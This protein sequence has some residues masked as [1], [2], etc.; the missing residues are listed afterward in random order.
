MAEARFDVADHR[1]CDDGIR[2]AKLVGSLA[3]IASLCG[4]EMSR[5]DYLI[6]ARA[7]LALRMAQFHER[8]D[9]LI[10]PTL[11]LTAFAAGEEVPP[12]MWEHPQPVA[13]PQAHNRLHAQKA[14]L[15]FLL[16]G[17]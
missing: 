17:N 13:F 10:T 11:P 1:A 4:C 15:E 14:I 7:A 9:L 2:C 5:Q 6:E 12:G 16:S 3:A 8:Y